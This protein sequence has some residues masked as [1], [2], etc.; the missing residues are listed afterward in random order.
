[1]E[2]GDELDHHAGGG[3]SRTGAVRMF[4]RAG[5]GDRARFGPTAGGNGNDRRPRLRPFDAYDRRITETRDRLR[6]REKADAEQLQQ[7]LKEVEQALEKARQEASQTGRQQLDEIEKKLAE[8]EK[9]L[10]GNG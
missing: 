7:Q 10:S 8:I 4:R 5:A 9:A 6:E 1:M 3:R 2:A